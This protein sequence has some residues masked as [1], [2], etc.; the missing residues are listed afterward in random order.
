MTSLF[1][2]ILY[3]VFGPLLFFF[4]NIFYYLVHSKNHKFKTSFHISEKETMTS[5]FTQVDKPLLLLSSESNDHPTAL[6]SIEMFLDKK[7]QSPI[8]LEHIQ[9]CKPVED[10]IQVDIGGHPP[11][12]LAQRLLSILAVFLQLFRP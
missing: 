1:Q 7:V 11:I 12:P 3:L 6:I 4:E 9:S 5:S 10:V 8:I 2:D